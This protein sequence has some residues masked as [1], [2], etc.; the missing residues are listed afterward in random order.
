MLGY[1]VLQLQSR[2][3]YFKLNITVVESFSGTIW[4]SLAYFFALREI[5]IWM[6]CR[7]RPSGSSQIKFLW[8]ICSVYLQFVFFSSKMFLIFN[9]FVEKLRAKHIFFN[10]KN[11]QENI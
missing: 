9:I 11:L 2:F 10:F 6:T 1:F 4:R 5:W 3:A 7:R 8:F